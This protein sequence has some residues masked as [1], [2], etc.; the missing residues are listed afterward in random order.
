MAHDQPHGVVHPSRFMD[1]AG[2]TRYEIALL[3]EARCDDPIEGIIWPQPFG[4]NAA[5]SAPRAPIIFAILV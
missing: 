3:V 4:R 5:G 2:R 1:D